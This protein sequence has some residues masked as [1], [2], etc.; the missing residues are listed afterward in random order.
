[1]D[2]KVQPTLNGVKFAVPRGTAFPSAKATG[3]LFHRT[4][5]GVICEWDGARWL[6]A[7]EPVA[8]TPWSV[9]PPFTT[10]T[11]AYICPIGGSIKVADGIALTRV[12]STNNATNYWTISCMTD[13]NNLS[14][15][16]TAAQ[17][18]D[19][20]TLAQWSFPNTIYSASYLNLVVAK[21]GTPGTLYLSGSVHIRKVYA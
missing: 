3:D 16:T 9:S 14:T 4:D 19:V 12:V 11:T 2:F 20:P 18:A 15:I 5:L 1:M 13:T 10:S 7:I 6:G 21:T 17:A 8:F